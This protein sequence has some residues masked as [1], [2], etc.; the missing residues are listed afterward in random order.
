MKPTIAE[1]SAGAIVYRI[2]DESPEI[3]LLENKGEHFE[4]AK[5]HLEKGEDLYECAKREVIEETGIS[6]VE[7]IDGFHEYFT[8][9][10]EYLR[11]TS[12]K[13]IHLFL[14]KTDEEVKI[15]SEHL[16]CKWV[17]VEEALKELDKEY[18]KHVLEKAFNEGFLV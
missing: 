9:K 2:T 8:V 4:F 13:T 7:L 14:V 10:K 5:G 18:E 15:S 1:I 16:S 11:D 12:F 17:S 3:L 6:T